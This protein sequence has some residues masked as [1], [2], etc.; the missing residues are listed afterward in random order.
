MGVVDD[1]SFTKSHGKPVGH[2]REQE[3]HYRQYHKA[4]NKGLGVA[5][6]LSPWAYAAQYCGSEQCEPQQEHGHLRQFG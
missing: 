4:D 3:T 5:L 1:D 2:F 6:F